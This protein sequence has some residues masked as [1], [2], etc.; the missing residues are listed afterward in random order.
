M[1]KC[2]DCIHYEVCQF[3]LDEETSLTVNE[4]TYGFKH[5]DQYVKLP[6]YLG[7]IVYDAEAYINYKKEVYSAIN[8]G[9]VSMLQQ[10]TDGSWKIRVSW[11]KR[12][13]GSQCYDISHSADYTVKEFSAYLHATKK[14]AEVEREELVNKR[15]MELKASE[16][17]NKENQNGK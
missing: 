16:D 7:Q 1:T 17:I 13:Q 8:K 14:A 2:K 5:K 4:C 11:Y 9:R 15:L 12:I 10:K 3:H 6:A